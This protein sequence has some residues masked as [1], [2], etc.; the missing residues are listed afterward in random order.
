MRRL[1]GYGV[2]FVFSFLCLFGAATTYIGYHA[3]KHPPRSPQV[4][5][6]TIEADER[7]GYVNRANLDLI[8]PY[9]VGQQ[10]Y[11]ATNEQRARREKPG[12]RVSS[13]AVLAIGDS[14]TFGSGISYAE[15]YTARLET[16]LGAPVLNLGVSGY[17]TVSAMRTAEELLPVRPKVL[18]LGYYYDHPARSVSPC[19]PGFMLRCLSVPYVVADR[20]GPRIVEPSDNRAVLETQRAYYRYVNGQAGYSFGQDFY[21]TSRRIWADYFQ[22][23]RLVFGRRQPDVAQQE[24]VDKFLLGN[25]NDLAGSVGARL[26]ILYIPN[27]FETKV[28]P[29]PD[30]LVELTKQLNIGF[31]DMTHDLQDAI[32]DNPNSI[33]VPHDGHLNALGHELMARRLYEKILHGSPH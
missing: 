6:S 29:P 19:Y 7:R 28:V 26:I 18:I 23:S 32:D 4:M 25:L 24:A 8:F 11:I 5:P 21:W 22:S 3:W 20:S 30:Y 10:F 12:G 2:L 27:Y 31:V 33:Q 13:A 1:L 16:V 14:Q 15:T 9:G 17:G